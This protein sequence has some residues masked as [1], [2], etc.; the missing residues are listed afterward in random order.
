MQ[1]QFF[2]GSWIKRQ[3][4]CDLLGFLWL[5]CVVY[6]SVIYR[7]CLPILLSCT[8]WK[9]ASSNKI[10]YKYWHYN[11]LTRISR[12]IYLG[13]VWLGAYVLCYILYNMVPLS[14]W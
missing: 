5:S 3:Y 2:A 9:P 1:L 8:S 6:L 4:L 11:V 12:P 14:G 7:Q 13:Y 10:T